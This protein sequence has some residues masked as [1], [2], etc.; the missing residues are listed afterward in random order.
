MA[1]AEDRFSDDAELVA[2]ALVR[3]GVNFLHGP[4]KDAPALHEACYEVLQPF[5]ERCRSSG[6]VGDSEIAS[7]IRTLSFLAAMW[8]CEGQAKPRRQP[9]EAAVLA[10][11]EA[12]EMEHL[13]WM[14]VRDRTHGAH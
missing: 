6:L 5:L 10:R 8:L 12:M 11:L 14:D 4:A 2:L 7:L 3:T 9:D 1:D 13:R